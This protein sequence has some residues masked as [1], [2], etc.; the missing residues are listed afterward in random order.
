MDVSVRKSSG[1]VTESGDRIHA[2]KNNV[3]I[4]AADVVKALGEGAGRVL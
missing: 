4:E 2:T 1:G 3:V